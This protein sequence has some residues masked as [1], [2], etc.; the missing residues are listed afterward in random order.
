MRYAS[1]KT[2]AAGDVFARDAR[3]QNAAASAQR[4]RFQLRA[5]KRP[6]MDGL[7]AR[8]GARQA[9]GDDQCSEKPGVLGGGRS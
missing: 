9:V 5:G 8:R 3:Y 6:A 7:S 4:T 2:S 1:P